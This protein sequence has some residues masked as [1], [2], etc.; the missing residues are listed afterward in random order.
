MESNPIKHNCL[1]YSCRMP[2]LGNEPAGCMRISISRSRAS[3]SILLKKPTYS[4]SYIQR[5]SLLFSMISARTI[6]ERATQLP[7]L[8]NEPHSCRAWGTN[9][10]VA[11]PGERATQLPSLRNEPLVRYSKL[12]YLTLLPVSTCPEVLNYQVWNSV[13]MAQVIKFGIAY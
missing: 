13:L 6:G 8:G 11:E 5:K 3:K 7:S 2:S 4:S 10:T 9:H 1:C 12:D